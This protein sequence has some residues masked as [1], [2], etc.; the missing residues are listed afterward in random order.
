MVVKN[1][2]LIIKKSFKILK[3]TT[4]IA[5][6]FAT[7]ENKFKIACKKQINQLFF[8]M[9]CVQ[10]SFAGQDSENKT[11]AMHLYFDIYFLRAIVGTG[12]YIQIENYHVRLPGILIQ[13]KNGFGQNSYRQFAF[14]N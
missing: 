6:T 8:F 2:A 7:I 1:E 9:I 4:I 12:S 14:Q 3:N 13:G 11:D 5:D 10:L